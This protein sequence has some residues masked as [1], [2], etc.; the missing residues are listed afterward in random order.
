MKE[1]DEYANLRALT[2][3]GLLE[4]LGWLFKN[5]KARFNRLYKQAKISSLASLSTALKIAK[6]NGLIAKESYTLSRDGELLLL[7]EEE[8][9]SGEKQPQLSLY[10]I[11]GKGKRVIEIAKNLDELIGTK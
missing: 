7:P 3:A 11:T 1:D 10:G 6:E 4:V 5:G 9:E 2:R 8:L